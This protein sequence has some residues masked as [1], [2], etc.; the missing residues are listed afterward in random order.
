MS[1]FEMTLNFGNVFKMED[2]N[3]HKE[4]IKECGGE[5]E[6]SWIDIDNDC[7]HVIVSVPMTA[8]SSFCCDFL[9]SDSYEALLEEAR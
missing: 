7:G 1:S 4:V 9:D 2:L 6:R 5:I 3:P 8:R